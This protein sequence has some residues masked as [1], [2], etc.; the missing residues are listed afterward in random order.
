MSSQRH[1]SFW[2]NVRTIEKLQNLR[3]LFKFALK[4][5]FQLRLN[6]D[7]CTVV[8]LPSKTRGSTRIFYRI[9]CKFALKFISNVG[10]KLFISRI[11]SFDSFYVER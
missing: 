6:I 1:G 2:E 7:L 5:A 9:I 4:V 3:I 10:L 8:V 11:Y